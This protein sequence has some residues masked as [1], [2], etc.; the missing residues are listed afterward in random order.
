MIPEKWNPLVSCRPHDFFCSCVYQDMEKLKQRQNWP[1]KKS[2]KGKDN[3]YTKYSG[4]LSKLRSSKFLKFK[5]YF[6]LSY[7]KGDL[8]YENVGNEIISCHYR[9]ITFIYPKETK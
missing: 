3:Q 7:S 9:T 4:L 8:L 5:I 1:Q 6:F 2:R